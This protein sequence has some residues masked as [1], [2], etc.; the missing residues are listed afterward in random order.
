MALRFHFRLEQLLTFRKQVEDS[1]I[2]D[3]ALAKGE[4]LKIE[5]SI[6]IHREKESDFLNTF[7]E[8]EKTG[9]FEADQGMA[10]SDYKNHLIRREDVLKKQEKAWREEVDRRRVLAIKAS[11]E[12]KLLINL[13]EKQQKAHLN[14]VTAEEQKFLDEISSIAFVRRERALKLRTA[15][16]P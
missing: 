15:G 16:M 9:V 2:K 4:L 1:R 7:S 12:K 6:R 5:D 11:R 13:R 8:M 10:F 3:L 14:E